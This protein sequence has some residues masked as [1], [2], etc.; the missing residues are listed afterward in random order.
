MAGSGIHQKQ[1]GA[2]DKVG[3]EPYQMQYRW[4][5]LALVWLL[6]CSFGLVARSIV[7]LITPILEGLNISYSN[8]GII[9]GAGQ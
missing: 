1:E 8:M 4:V 7:P 9:L 5:M 2:I 6:Y 3:I